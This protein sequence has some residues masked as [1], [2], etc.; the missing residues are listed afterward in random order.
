MV[1]SANARHYRIKAAQRDLIDACGGIERSAEIC[2]YGKST[3][4]RWRDIESPDW[5]K[6]DAVE[7]LETE[8]GLHVWTVAWLESRG[9]KLVTA[10]RDV[11]V[12][13]LTSQMA[14]LVGD[15]GALMGEWAVTA[16]DGHA[17][18]AEADRMRKSLSP[19][20]DR[21]SAIEDALAGVKAEGGLSLVKGGAA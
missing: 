19:L 12:A 6:L 17:T 2:G 4:G 18:P 5:M 8:A 20:R 16:A 11:K 15:L 21:F 14:G 13:C 10:E 9:L 1:P 3:V 7:K